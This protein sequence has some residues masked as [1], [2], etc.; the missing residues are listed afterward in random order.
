MRYCSVEHQKADWVCH[1]T[2]CSVVPTPAASALN[3]V[4]VRWI[5]RER[6]RG[7]FATNDLKVGTTTV[8]NRGAVLSF[9]H[10]FPLS[11]GQNAAHV[12][13][14][15]NTALVEFA[16]I[17]ATNNDA[18]PWI[19]LCSAPGV[20]D[21]FK[22]QTEACLRRNAFV[23]HHDL[24]SG[25]PSMTMAAWIFKP[26]DAFLNHSCLPNCVS[27]PAR[28]CATEV[29]PNGAELTISYANEYVALPC[30]YRRKF[31]ARRLNFECMCEVCS[32]G[33]HGMPHPHEQ[34]LE[35]GTDALDATM[36]QAMEVEFANLCLA[37]DAD[38]LDA[39]STIPMMDATTFA[40]WIQSADTFVANYF[41]KVAASHSNWRRI[42]LLSWI[43]KFA[44]HFHHADL[45]RKY[46]PMLLESYAA[47]FVDSKNHFQMGQ[48]YELVAEACGGNAE[49][50]N[51]L[52]D[53]HPGILQFMQ[54]WADK[55]EL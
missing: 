48:A 28:I 36:Y 34:R 23:R 30:K 44:G 12:R 24:E 2:V 33:V 20:Y 25:T 39:L 27:F 41:T 54:L 1:K 13:D 17:L 22:A 9:R 14:V 50:L 37:H 55:Q 49:L 42:K 15:E 5:S 52:L 43:L 51:E 7:V 53:A 38:P 21:S 8:D 45:T 3:E 47:L 11:P 19:K 46:A 4:E 32:I 10:P 18:K 6:G 16:H 35:A 40:T 26:L 29:I 31:I